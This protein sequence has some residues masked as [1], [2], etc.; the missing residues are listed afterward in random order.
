M[1]DKKECTLRVDEEH[2]IE[3][4]FCCFNNR[5]LQHFTDR[6]DGNIELGDPKSSRCV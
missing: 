3:F 6:I 5:L 1:L 4:L 2:I